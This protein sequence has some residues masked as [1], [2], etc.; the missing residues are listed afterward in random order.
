MNTIQLENRILSTLLS[1]P[2]KLTD[3]E[4]I[5]RP[6]CFTD[7]RKSI[8]EAIVSLVEQEIPVDTITIYQELKRNEIDIKPTVIT[9]I[10]D[11]PARLDKLDLSV[12]MLY[13]EFLRK[14]LSKLSQTI[15]DKIKNDKDPFDIISDVSESIDLLEHNIELKE[16]KMIDDLPA[17]FEGIEEKMKGKGETGLMSE[18]FPSLN[19]ATGGIMKTD[20]VVIFGDYKQGKSTCVEQIFLDIAFDYKAVGVFN[21]EMTKEILY[22]KALSMRTG[23]DYLKLR[24]PRG[25]NNFLTPEEFAF[26]KR[27][28]YEIFDGTKLYV[29]DKLFDIDKIILKMRAWKKKYKIELFVIDYLGLLEGNKKFTQRHLEVANYSRRIKN[30]AKQLETPIIV[31]S[32]ANAEG[33]TAESKNPARDAD[34]VISVCKPIEA[35]I[36][37]IKKKDSTELFTFTADHFLITVENSRHGKNKQNAVASFIKN[38]FVEIDINESPEDWGKKRHFHESEAMELPI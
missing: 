29:E 11:E 13:E 3:V 12:K 19:N 5:L 14:E 35:G 22:Y 38:N 37:T 8:Y 27:K 36:N 26:V 1:F 17:L 23:I 10:P 31:L 16:T 20:Y 4:N 24:N 2:E 6:Q 15:N 9:I 34:F 33:K 7:I 25:R 21:L 28:A 30:L 18:T 32:Q